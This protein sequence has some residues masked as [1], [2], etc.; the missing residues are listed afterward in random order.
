MTGTRGSDTRKAIWSDQFS[1]GPE[2][3]AVGTGKGNLAQF[4]HV[5]TKINGG[6]FDIAMPQGVP[7]GLDVDA[8]CCMSRVA[9]E[10]RNTWVPNGGKFQPAA[11]ETVLQHVVNRGRLQGNEWGSHAQEELTARAL[12][13]ALRR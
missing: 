1:I 3:S 11:S 4:I 9:K 2:A 7:D 10:C 5:Q 13:R 6:A 8:P 12:G